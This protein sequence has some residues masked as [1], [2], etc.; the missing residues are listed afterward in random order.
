MKLKSLEKIIY[1]PL[2]VRLGIVYYFAEDG[3][4]HT[5]MISKVPEKIHDYY[6]DMYSKELLYVRKQ[7]TFEEYMDARL[8]KFSLDEARIAEYKI[9]EKASLPLRKAMALL[10][11]GDN[12]SDLQRYLKESFDYYN[13]MY[14]VMAENK[15]FYHDKPEGLDR[16]IV[17]ILKPVILQVPEN[18]N[19]KT[20]DIIKVQ[21]D[22]I[23]QWETDRTKYIKDNK[24]EIVRRAVEKI[25]QDN[26]F[27]KFGVDVNVLAL[28]KMLRL[29]DNM[30][31]LIFELKKELREETD[32]K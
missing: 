15:G 26:A 24:K 21:I 20:F 29:N 6:Q 18:D 9:E 3:V 12:Y 14:K 25:A 7:Y 4:I 11:E 22:I 16:F 19:P 28:T 31:E 30:I 5:Q 17:K 13:N 32:H 2:R 10:K 23:S 27:R 1:I 8:K